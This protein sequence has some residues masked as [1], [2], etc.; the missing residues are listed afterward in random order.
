MRNAG[1]AFQMRIADLIGEI[2]HARDAARALRF[3]IG[4]DGDAAGIVAAI[5]QPPQTFDQ[6]RY[7]V[8]LR[9]RADNSAHGVVLYR[10]FLNRS[11]TPGARHQGAR[12]ST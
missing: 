6:H 1:C 7:D 2:G 4:N 9:N 12:S 3:A 10:L 11:K 5:F 8:T